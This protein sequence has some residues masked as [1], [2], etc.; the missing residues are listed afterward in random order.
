M[1]E[2]VKTLPVTPNHKAPEE[3]LIQWLRK[4]M[5]DGSKYAVL[6]ESPD[7]STAQFTN[8]GSDLVGSDVEAARF[9]EKFARAI[10]AR[11]K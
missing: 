2:N 8:L 11:S 6:I 4:S 10:R 9:F 3:I 5:A 7:G 1:S